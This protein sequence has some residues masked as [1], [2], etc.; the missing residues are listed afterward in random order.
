MSATRSPSVQRRNWPTYVVAAV[1]AVLTVLAGT[2]V[3]YTTSARERARF[4]NLVRQDVENVNQRLSNY[5]TMLQGAAGLFSA[6]DEVTREEFHRY[7][8]HL[9]LQEQFSGVQGIGY[10]RRVRSGDV[11]QVT[12]DMKRQ[13]VAG[14]H[15]FPQ[16]PR[17]EYHAI[18][19]LEPLDRRNQAAIGYDM[20]T[21]PVR[22][23]AMSRAWEDGQAAASGV[24]TLVQEIDS[25][26]QPGFLIYVPVYGD[27]DPPRTRQE[28]R[29][30]LDGFV[31]S[32]FR[33]GDLLHNILGTSMRRELSL[34]VLDVTEPTPQRLFPVDS[35]DSG[36]ENPRFAGRS[37]LN[38]AGRTW[39]LRFGS[40]PEFD[41]ASTSRGLTAYTLAGGFL[42]TGA[43]LSMMLAQSKARARAERIASELHESER[44][45]RRSES[46]FRLLFEQAPI[47]LQSFGADGTILRAN[48]AWSQL[49]EAPLEALAGYNILNDPQLERNGMGPY[50]RRAYAGEAVAVPPFYFDPADSNRTGRPRWLEAVVYPVRDTAGTVNEVVLILQDVTER[51]IAEQQRNQLL[52]REQEARREAQNASRLKDEFLATVSHELRT[53][54]NAILGWS[55]LLREERISA[56]DLKQGLETIERNARAQSKLIEDLLDVSRIISGQ[57]RL[58]MH[59]SDLRKIVQSVIETLRPAAQAKQIQVGLHTKMDAAPVRGDPNRLQQVVWN[60]ISNAIKFTPPNGRVDTDLG[61]EDGS[62]KLVVRDTGEGIRPDFLPFV[63][64]AFRQ[65]DGSSK[66]RQGGLG[67][68]LAIVRQ[69]VELHGGT[70]HADS[71]GEGRGSAFTVILPVAPGLSSRP[72]VIDRPAEGTNGLRGVR[73]LLVEDD[74]DARDLLQRVLEN[75]GAQVFAVGSGP[76]AM[77]AL[78]EH[79]PQVLLSDIGMPQMDGYELIRQIRRLPPQEGGTIPAAALTAFAR[80]EDRRRAVMAGYQIHVSKPVEAAELTSVVAQLA[81]RPPSAC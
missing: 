6:S 54:L 64:N 44:A 3:W 50:V 69:L 77:A 48:R 62:L 13:G 15:I 9:Q 16:S 79:H 37:E 31:Y 40:T 4:D 18:V 74:D 38:V 34:V 61:V 21:D 10:S 58:D 51:N 42:A 23:Q 24:V 1:A 39:S 63:F 2:Y 73:V 68:G 8:D 56:Q 17:D 67:L 66:R 28:R 35:S 5:I 11:E 65:G 22:Q 52:E 76:E 32:P 14:F 80:M 7:V 71:E 41:A 29:N 75:A 53:P 57:L 26:K 20:F 47:A 59:E 19:Y 25:D 60:L 81:G 72:A 78:R 30:R 36:R 33:A 46:R 55:Q 12:A 27:I 45:L 49:W 70:I 43:L